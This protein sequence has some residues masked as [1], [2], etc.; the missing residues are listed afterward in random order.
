MNGLKSTA[1]P[2]V[3]GVVPG[4]VLRGVVDKRPCG[5]IWPTGKFSIGYAPGLSES[6]PD[7]DGPFSGRN[8]LV[9]PEAVR[10]ACEEI[11][12]SMNLGSS[13]VRNPHTAAS[14]RPET[15]GRRGCSAYGRNMVECGVMMLEKWHP[16]KELSF[17]TLTVPPLPVAELRAV[18]ENWAEAIRQLNQWLKRR[19][20]NSGLT[21]EIVGVTELQGKR[22]QRGDVGALHYH[23]VFH[24]KEASGRWAIAYWEVRQQ[25]LAILSRLTGTEVNSESCE[26]LVHVEKS[27]AAYL[28]KYLSKGSA[29]VDA[30]V[31]RYGWECVPRQWW[32]MSNS[33][34]DKVKASV[35][36]EPE[37]LWD[38]EVA[39]GHELGGESTAD[40]EF[41]RYITMK[42][43]SGR[44]IVMGFTGKLGAGS[45]RRFQQERDYWRD[46]KRA[47]F[48]I[49]DVWL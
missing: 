42:G 15:Y 34:R 21:G 8:R 46:A 10:D 16:T 41:L 3:N 49:Q 4:R 5:R 48:D 18:A 22:S 14:K 31:A 19:L 9:S 40:F 23:S 24:G 25:W 1:L 43:E 45:L 11:S 26:N 28:G 29:G 38:L 12:E 32:N 35:I 20:Q 39:I 30:I 44:D 36:T 33:L 27:A 13:E 47:A 7:Y 6:L 37:V 2:K 17:L